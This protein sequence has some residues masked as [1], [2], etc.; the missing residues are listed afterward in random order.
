MQT[1]TLTFW[2]YPTLILVFKMTKLQVFLNVTAQHG[3]TVYTEITFR[4]RKC[5]RNI[6][7]LHSIRLL[8]PR[9]TMLCVLGAA[10]WAQI[11]IE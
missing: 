4:A 1:T 10:S 7:M 11:Q 3:Y 9:L 6:W 5:R 8:C 2:Y